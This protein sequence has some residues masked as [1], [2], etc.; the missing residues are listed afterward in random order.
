M[1]FRLAV[2]VAVLAVAMA[3]LDSKLIA[4]LR[5]KHNAMKSAKPSHRKISA[6]NIK[7]QTVYS[8]YLTIS[9]YDDNSNCATDP[10]LV[11]GLAF[12]LCI[13]GDVDA[14]TGSALTSVKYYANEA[15]D[16]YMSYFSEAGDCSGASTDNLVS[17]PTPCIN[18]NMQVTKQS[19]TEPWGSVNSDGV[20][21]K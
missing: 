19:S 8:I 16:T 18:S 1:I 14:T 20:V 2:L 11:M 13:A 21:M 5:N 3:E 10:N 15:G 4:Q 17:V 9:N 12:D 6:E 7:A